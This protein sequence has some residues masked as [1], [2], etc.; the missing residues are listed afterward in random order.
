MVALFKWLEETA[1]QDIDSL[2]HI[3]RQE[4]RQPN[5]PDIIEVSGAFEE[6]LAPHYYPTHLSNGSPLYC[7]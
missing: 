4:L 5:S 3:N 6:I 1:P 2:S 7:R